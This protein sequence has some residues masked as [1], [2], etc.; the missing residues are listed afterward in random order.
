MKN[1]KIANNIK[2]LLSQPIVYEIK[3]IVKEA[4]NIIG[5]I[6]PHGIRNCELLKTVFEFAYIEGKQIYDLNKHAD[7]IKEELMKTIDALKQCPKREN[8]NYYVVPA[9]TEI[10]CSHVYALLLEKEHNI[11]PSTYAI[12][13]FL[14][15]ERIKT[16][17]FVEN[18]SVLLYYYYQN[19]ADVVK[20]NGIS[21]E[22]LL[23]ER[24]IERHMK[25][26]DGSITTYTMLL[27]IH[28]RKKHNGMPFLYYQDVYSNRLFLISIKP[29]INNRLPDSLV[30]SMINEVEDIEK[31]EAYVLSEKYNISGWLFDMK[32]L[33]VDGC[34]NI[35]KDIKLIDELLQTILY[36]CKRYLIYNKIRV[37]ETVVRFGLENE[38]DI[39]TMISFLNTIA[40][41]LEEYRIYNHSNLNKSFHI[42]HKI[43][44]TTEED[45]YVTKDNLRM[46]LDTLY[47]NKINI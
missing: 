1:Q 9:V 18:K 30:T 6:K 22:N 32:K 28:Y 24:M 16:I 27:S 36:V 7:Y 35:T 37:I 47:L 43:D 31:I 2:H 41:N 46:V 4:N 12:Y 11:K 10:L 14:K 15:L 23:S 21:L 25:Y 13:E 17:A 20:D 8:G 3:N 33:I 34:Y 39:R 45:I 42:K 19:Y 5:N 26:G 40:L 44:E 38:D 29:Y